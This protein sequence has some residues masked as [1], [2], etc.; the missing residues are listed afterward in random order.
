MVHYYT[1][2]KAGLYTYYE[3]A[4]MENGQNAGDQFRWGTMTVVFFPNP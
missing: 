2:P 4:Y 1:V 3:N